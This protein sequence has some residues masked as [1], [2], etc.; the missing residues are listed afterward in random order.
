MAAGAW[1]LAMELFTRGNALFVSELRRLQA[2]ERLGDFASKWYADPRPFA[3]QALLEYLALP[4]SCYRHEALVKRLFKLAEKA[5]DD[6]VMGAFLAAFDRTIRRERRDLNR[7][8]HEEFADRD[9][10]N[11]AIERWADEGY[12]LARVSEWSGRFHAFASKNV[13]AITVPANTVMPRPDKARWKRETT[14]A[15]FVRDRYERRFVLFSLPTRRYLRR[16]AWRY[17]RRLG[18]TDPTRYLH[19]AQDFL[20]RYTDADTGSDLNLLDNWG[21]VHALFSN[22]PALRNTAKGWDFVADRSLSDLVPAPRFEQ[23]WRDHPHSLFDILLGAPS[24]VVRQW[25]LWLLR[26]HHDAW[27]AARPITTLLRLIDHAEPELANL[28]FDLLERAEHLEDVPIEEWLLRLNGDNFET[29]TRLASLLARKFDA[30]RM[31]V[32]DALRLAGFRSK[33]VAEFGLGILKQRTFTERDT[34]V[35]L[36]LVQAECEAMRPEIARWLR[37]TL[38]SFGEPQSAWV[39]EFLD[40]KHRDVRAAG[41]EWLNGS[42]LA[43]DPAIWQRLTES[44]YDDLRGPLVEQLQTRV[45]SADRDSIQRLWANVL[46]NVA[47]GGRYKPGIVAQVSS[48]LADHPAEA[49][50]LLPLLAVAVRSLR[51]PEF[52]AG[53]VGIVSLVE[54][55]P[56]LLPIVRQKFPELEF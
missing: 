53:L 46:L 21:L 47:R 38:E 26:T 6:I 4:L 41:W 15:D 54:R 13:E 17:F 11:A 31:P 7:H 25:A 32:D 24:R 52:R 36:P 9:S 19:A 1:S 8:R 49:D 14:V 40:S 27:L 33:P 5:N 48:R 34:P 30:N 39:I 28:G 50:R 55:Q 2:A 22:S 20:K 12:E 43:N 37:G 44:P 3:R 51:G 10:A 56:E 16:R 42:P 35:L 29:L 18:A 45:A 23:I